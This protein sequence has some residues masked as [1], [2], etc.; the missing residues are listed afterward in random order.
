MTRIRTTHRNR[1]IVSVLAMMFIVIFSALAA[2]MAIVS[3]GNLQTANTYQHVN[4]SLAA[5][6]TGMKWAQYRVGEIAASI[7]TPKGE[8]D[9]ALADQIWPVMRDQI[10]TD[11]GSELHSL[12]N[13]TLVGDRLTLGRIAVDDSPN[14]PT[15]QIVIERHPLAGEDYGSDYY[16]RAPYNVGGGAN[17]L[18]ANGEAVSATNPI[19]SVWVRLRSVGTDTGYSR[20]VQMDFRLDKKIRFAILSR[21]R[22]MIGRNV[23]IKGSIGSRFTQVNLKNG[24]PVQMRDNFNGLDPQLDQWLDALDTYLAAHDGNGDNRINLASD[25]E[26]SALD[27][28]ASYDANKDG[29]VDAYD[30]FLLKYDTN[31]DGKLS[32]SEFTNSGGQMVDTQLW[33]LINE[34]KYPAGTQFDWTNNRVLLP[35]HSDWTDVGND[36]TSI[37]NDDNYAKIAG[38]IILSASKSAWEAGAAGGEYQK[39]LEG[40]IKPDPNDPSLTFDASDSD[41][42]SFDA[43]DIDVSQ[44]QNKATGSFATQVSAAVSSGSG[45]PQYIAPSAATIEAVPY[46]SPHPY[47]YYKR[48]VYKNYTF[49]NVTIPMG[50]NALFVNCKFKGVTFVQTEAHNSDPNFNYA[51]TQNADGT[52][53]YENVVVNV[54][55]TN[56]TDTKP[57]G[58]NVRFDGCTFEGMVAS[59]SPE[60]FTH[61]RNKLQ[62]TGAT[63]FNLNADDISASDKKFYEKST[64]MTPQMSVDMGSFDDP[65]STS[66]YVHLDGTIVAGVFDIRGNATLDGSILTTYEPKEGDGALANGGNPAMFNTTIGYFES[67]AGDGEAEVPDG[68]YGKIIIRYNP[69]R[70]LPD[71]IS[72]PI[73]MSADVDTYHEGR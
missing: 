22:V 50:T 23:V 24:H 33:Q 71:G 46:N 11:M 1:G 4:R 62:F 60:A 59:T 5:A 67:S 17:V 12:E 55:G 36:F 48:P 42:S 26:S 6:E 30:M 54:N 56:V 25:S 44:Y 27:D 32:A 47:D 72:G 31:K 39:Y 13:Y 34:V 63:A 66:Q 69:H 64:I 41:L 52:Q 35:G 51:G 65:A 10:I 40:P 68:G 61:V 19:S 57:Y 45:T 43:S 37:D 58:N 21:N 14:A 20:A 8:I 28:A 49:T 7:T 15:F 38:Q 53:A 70:V 29:F 3:Q 16:Q 18:T 73:E 9:E 2:A